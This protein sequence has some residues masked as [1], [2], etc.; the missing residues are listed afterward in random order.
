M[1]G[2]GGILSVDPQER[3][4]IHKMAFNLQHRGPD[5]EGYFH[6]EQIAL[7]QT[8][9]SIIDLKTGHQPMFSQDKSLVLVCNG[10]I[11]N[12]PELRKNLES[13]G[14]QFQTKTDVEVI[15]HLYEDYGDDCVNYLQ[16]MFAFAIWDRRHKRLLLARDHMGQKPLFFIRS[17]QSIYFA[18]EIKA[19]LATGLIKPQME[20][21]GL[22]HYMSLRYLP[23]QFTFFKGIEKLPAA[24]RVIFENNETRLEQYWDIDFVKKHI[25]SEKEIEDQLHKTLFKTVQ[26]HMLSDVDVGAFLSGGIDSST[27][28]AMMATS[29]GSGIP[30]FSI[31]VKEQ[32]FNE[33]PYARL[34]AQQYGMS[35]HEEIVEPNMIH[36]IPQ[37][38]RS[39]DEPSDPFG[40][41]VFQ[42]AQLA[43]KHVKVVLSGD[44]GDE[45]FAGY[46]RFAGQKIADYYSM[47]PLWLRQNVL[48]KLVNAIPDTFEYKSL[49]QKARWLNE[50][51]LRDQ[52][53]R[54]AHSMS[55]LRFTDESKNSLFTSSAMSDFDS[56]DSKENIL[57]H[58]NS[59]NVDD[60]VDRM[61]YT[62]LMTR[63]PDHLLTIAD[64]MCMTHSLENRSPL[65][66]KEV[67]E[68]A[69]GIPGHMKLK[70]RKLK[71]IL[72]SVASRYLPNELIYRKKQGF[73][74]PIA[75]WLRHDLAHFLRNLF[76]ES[77]FVELGI[78][79][80]KS[81]N[82]LLD[83]HLSGKIDHNFRIWI[84][85]N[86]ELWYRLYFENTS[87]DEMRDLTDKL[88]R[89]R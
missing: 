89:P 77:R 6:D 8:R 3:E 17:G 57:K 33:L 63:I 39:L 19:L 38:I 26:S 56:K 84:L 75:L 72:R 85:L 36:N 83:E 28:S 40:L 2:I 71:H 30:V 65:L 62:D 4:V 43:S 22:W 27:I 54:Y 31:G 88:I 48:K 12:S 70:G 20:L 78:F 13:Q 59:V 52:G 87:V 25:G 61:L 18:S 42:V 80:R 67:V 53:D 10:E 11:Y 74:F 5:D 66:D 47:L 64:R 21:E 73:G 76:A 1:C 32:S 9:L 15:L 29:E 35:A 24:S 23:D 41:G 16:G 7:T 60:L 79:E 45:N 34:V 44:G 49:A 50:M 86:L 68:F 51:S 82:L 55:Y 58:F 14:H 81:I 69:A 37:L 46:D